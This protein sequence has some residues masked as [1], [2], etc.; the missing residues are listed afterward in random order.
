MM[1]NVQIS[2]R[3]DARL[4]D[5]P[6]ARQTPG[7]ENPD[8]RPMFVSEYRAWQYLGQ[9]VNSRPVGTKSYA[10]DAAGISSADAASNLSHARRMRKSLAHRPGRAKRNVTKSGPTIP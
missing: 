10:H 4:G 8:R 9:D 7:S 6:L 2:F 5:T 3:A 1:V